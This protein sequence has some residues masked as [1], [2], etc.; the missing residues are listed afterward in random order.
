M[1]YPL[2]SVI[3]PAYNAELYI[4][5][6]LESVL[7]QTYQEFEIIVIDDGSTD[8]Q[9]EI[10]STLMEKDDRIKY[11]YQENSGVSIARNH[12]ILLSKGD[13][14]AFLDADDVWYPN[15][16]ELK[17]EK[18]ESGKFGLVHSSANII[19]ERSNITGQSIIGKEGSLLEDML[20]WKETCI[21]GPSSVLVKKEVIEEIGDFDTN[22]STAADQ[23]FFFRVAS[24][25]S[26]G[27]VEG[28]TWNY[29]LH[30][31]NMHKYIKQMEQDVLYV[32]NKAA[33]NG[34]F[35][36]KSFKH[37]CFAKMY[38]IL[39]ASWWGD[40]KNK[41]RAIKYILKSILT[42]PTILLNK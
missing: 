39:A 20:M 30:E 32:Y 37:K 23:D 42:D 10:I 27:R 11:F 3:I 4:K 13:Y 8:N 35:Q 15:N 34:L 24:K 21:P 9:K 6:A 17:V 14:L 2:V 18:F 25:Y 12:G 1:N 29:R 22:L 33:K 7:G 19:D 40:G 26:I 31:S 38:K 5:E 16:L 28:I 36:N 41:A